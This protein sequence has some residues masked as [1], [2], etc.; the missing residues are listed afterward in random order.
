MLYKIFRHPP[1]DYVIKIARAAR[2]C[3]YYYGSTAVF[4]LPKLTNNDT[5]PHP[6]AGS[7]CSVSPLEV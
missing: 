6:A 2:V 7:R 1:Y 3:I 5:A 4:F